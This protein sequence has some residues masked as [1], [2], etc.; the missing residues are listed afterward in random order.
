MRKD[1]LVKNFT[2]IYKKE[3]KMR[4]FLLLA[5]LISLAAC[6]VMSERLSEV[7]RTPQLSRVN[8]YEEPLDP[9]KEK[10]EARIRSKYLGYDNGL[11]SSETRGSGAPHT[12]QSNPNS[13]WKKGSRSFLK[14]YALGDIISVAVSIS[15]QA[16]LDNQ[17]Q[18]T[19]NSGT[20][21]KAPSILGI[22]NIINDFLPA[23]S[24]SS[25]LI[26]LKSNDSASGNGKVNRK[27]VVQTTIAVT[28]IKVFPSGNLLVKG[29]QE[30]RVNHDIREVT[31]EGIIR[32][33]DISKDNK[34]RLDQIAE[35]RVS[36]GGRGKI[37]EY[38]PPYG[39]EVLEIISPF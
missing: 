7:G 25:G 38:Q 19:R 18:K 39:K 32:P 5:N 22:E 14:P 35:A 9:I 4:R 36:Y 12:N 33:E 31:I 13:L 29:S 17:S 1:N 26:N 3:K 16:K 30:V 15:D 8:Y 34:V 21:L 23:S 2:I 11:E 6:D 10:V 28:V 20:S 24:Q 37:L 27:E